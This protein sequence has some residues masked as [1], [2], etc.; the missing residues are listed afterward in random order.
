MRTLDLDELTLQTANIYEAAVILS[1]RSRQIAA[2]EK[3]ELD[4]RLAYFEGFGSDVENIRM[5]EEQARVSLEF[6][7]K[8]KPTELAVNEMLEGEIYFRHPSEED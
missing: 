7:V 4:D 8:P 2:R 3:T 6:E 1:K 5:Q